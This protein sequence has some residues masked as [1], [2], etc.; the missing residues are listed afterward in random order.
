MMGNTETEREIV[1][2]PKPVTGFPCLLHPANGIDC[3]SEYCIQGELA[4]S[5]DSS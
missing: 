4:G 5:S 2:F 3:I 1:T